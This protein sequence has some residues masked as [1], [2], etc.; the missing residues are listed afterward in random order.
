MQTK[1]FELHAVAFLVFFLLFN[2][3]L[4][5]RS[6]SGILSQVHIQGA[7]SFADFHFHFYYFHF[8]YSFGCTYPTLPDPTLFLL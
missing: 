8:H 2:P 5:V 7:T 4:V 6:L 1:V 3:K